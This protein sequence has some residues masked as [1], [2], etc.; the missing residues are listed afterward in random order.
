MTSERH[1]SFFARKSP[2]LSCRFPFFESVKISRNSTIR[3]IRNFFFV[4]TKSIGSIQVTSIEQPPMLSVYFSSRFESKTSQSCSLQLGT[5]LTPEVVPDIFRFLRTFA[6][7]RR[8]FAAARHFWIF[9]RDV[10]V[11]SHLISNLTGPPTPRGSSIGTDQVFRNV[12]TEDIWEWRREMQSILGNGKIPREW[13]PIRRGLPS[14]KRVG[15]ANH[16]QPTF[17]RG[18][19]V[20]NISIAPIGHS[21]SKRI[22]HQPQ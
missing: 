13:S 19:I 11:L 7:T 16:W 5:K 12:A 17:L 10:L 9:P 2:V 20:R 6:K 22:R 3:G 1:L 14:K 8:N 15:R 4:L 18:G 21:L